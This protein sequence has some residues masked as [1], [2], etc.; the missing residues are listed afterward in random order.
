[1]QEEDKKDDVEDEVVDMK[2]EVKEE[3]QVKQD[4]LEFLE[5]IQVNLDI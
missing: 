3:E 2:E 1:M 5:K 4:P